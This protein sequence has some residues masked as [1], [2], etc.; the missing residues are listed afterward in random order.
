[1]LINFLS[2]KRVGGLIRGRGLIGDGGG[3]LNRRFTVYILLIK[4]DIKMVG[5][6]TVRQLQLQTIVEKK[7]NS[8]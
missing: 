6:W 4:S 2:R 1:M 7:I 8:T 3:G 5:Y